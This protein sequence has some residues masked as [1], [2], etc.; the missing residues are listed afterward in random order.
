MSSIAAESKGALAWLINMNWEQDSIFK[1]PITCEQDIIE[2]MRVDL[3]DEMIGSWLNSQSRFLVDDATPNEA[4]EQGRLQEVIWA[5][6]GYLSG[7]SYWEYYASA[8]RS[9]KRLPS[10]VIPLPVK[11]QDE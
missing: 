5:A 8:A 4:L 3:D 10:N 7:K 1:K 6:D 2:H 9:T 11:N